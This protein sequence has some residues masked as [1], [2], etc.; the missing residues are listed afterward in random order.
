MEEKAGIT[1]DDKKTTNRKLISWTET[2]KSVSLI[3]GSLTLLLDNRAHLEIAINS[4]Q[5]FARYRLR[6]AYKAQKERVIHFHTSTV[7]TDWSAKF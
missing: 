7:S 5:H 1:H 3:D 2:E 4:V 6:Q